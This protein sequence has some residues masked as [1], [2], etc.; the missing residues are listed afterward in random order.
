MSAMGRKQTL[1]SRDFK[2]KRFESPRC[3]GGLLRRQV[4]SASISRNSGFVDDAGGV[5]LVGSL[6]QTGP[7]IDDFEDRHTVFKAN[8]GEAVLL[9][10]ECTYRVRSI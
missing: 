1:A 4:A 5:L 8:Q 9:P 6:D 2:M 7:G 10:R 3:I